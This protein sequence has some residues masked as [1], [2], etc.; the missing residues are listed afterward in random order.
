MHSYKTFAAFML[1]KC[2]CLFKKAS[3]LQFADVITMG[4]YI[5]PPE[6]LNNLIFNELQLLRQCFPAPS[7]ADAGLGVLIG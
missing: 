3:W 2:L 4:H 7:N 6:G 5:L 1:K